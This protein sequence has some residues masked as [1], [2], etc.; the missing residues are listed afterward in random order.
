MTTIEPD[1]PRVVRASSAVLAVADSLEASGNALAPSATLAAA[2][3]RGYFTPDEDDG[4]RTRYRTY[5]A[6]RGALLTALS[7]MTEAG[8]DEEADWP[9][10]LPAFSVALAAACLLLTGAREVIE[11]ADRSRLLRKKLDEA[12]PRRGIPRKTFARIYRAATH[13]RRLA[14]FQQAL[15][16]GSPSVLLPRSGAGVSQSIERQREA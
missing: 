3:T 13:P 4:I 8:A 2:E 9:A 12:D 14:L 6:G 10:R 11:S 1:D 16:F 5:L 7:E 15:K